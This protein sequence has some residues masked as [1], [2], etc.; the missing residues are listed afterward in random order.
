MHAKAAIAMALSAYKKSYKGGGSSDWHLSLFRATRS[1]VENDGRSG[2]GGGGVRKKKDDSS[3][4]SSSD[5]RILYPGSHR[6]LTPALVFPNINFVDY[7]GKVGPLYQSDAARDYVVREKDYSEDPN[8][9]FTK[10][11]Y[12]ALPKSRDFAEDSFDLLISLSA[13]IVSSPCTRY[14]KPGGYLLVSDAHSD[15]RAAFVSDD[16]ELVAV[17]DP[18]AEVMDTSDE[19]LQRCFRVV[20]CAKRRRRRDDDDGIDETNLPLISKSQVDE[21]ERVGTVRKRSFT[22]LF[23]P[24]VYLFKRIN[25]DECKNDAA[26]QPIQ[27]KR[28]KEQ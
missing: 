17:W 6:H 14:V 10:A 19:T 7:D 18:E 26:I 2:G 12:E 24:L 22:L 9:T 11:R 23:E 20:R 28:R 27:K 21:S 1:L 25:R 16:W 3:S 4:S 15:A 8:Y 13:G 5:L